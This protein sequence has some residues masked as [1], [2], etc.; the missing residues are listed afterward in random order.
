MRRIKLSVW[1]TQ[2]MGG[3]IAVLNLLPRLKSLGYAIRRVG[4]ITMTHPL[5]L[6]CTARSPAFQ[7]AI[8]FLAKDYT[9]NRH[10]PCYSCGGSCVTRLCHKWIETLNMDLAN[11]AEGDSRVIVKILSTREAVPASAG[12]QVPDDVY[13]PESDMELSL[14]ARH[15]HLIR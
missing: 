6:V 8:V 5:M 4:V 3:L 15:D 11:A 9:L 7:K 14:R 2:F 12:T 13:I 1:G 10:Y